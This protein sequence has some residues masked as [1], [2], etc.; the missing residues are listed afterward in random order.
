MLF[1]TKPS[2]PYDLALVQ[3]RASVTDA[4]TPRMADRFDQGLFLY[5]FAN[6][7]MHPLTYSSE[8]PCLF[9]SVGDSVVVVGYGGMGRQC[10]PSLTSG[11]ISKAI[12]LKDQLVMLQTTCAVQAG[13]SGGAVVQRNS[14]EL[15]GRKPC[16]YN[17][18]RSVGAT[19][20][21]PKPFKVQTSLSRNVLIVCR[22]CIQQHKGPGCQSDLSPPQLRHS[23]DCFPEI[24][25]T[26]SP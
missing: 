8:T 6:F 20:T 22:H 12:R 7:F 18:V 10:G 4:V 2:S 3:L 16:C 25:T 14:G 26:V 1:S 9:S 17:S 13:A 19:W 24:V 23:S 5:I 21:P 15:L 11:V